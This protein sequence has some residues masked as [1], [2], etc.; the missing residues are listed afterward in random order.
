MLFGHFIFSVDRTLQQTAA[1]EF[2]LIVF[3]FLHMIVCA[4]RVAS[5]IS[6]RLGKPLRLLLKSIDGNRAFNTVFDIL[7]NQALYYYTSV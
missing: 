1:A 2:G 5:S 4:F 7:D 6:P 3:F